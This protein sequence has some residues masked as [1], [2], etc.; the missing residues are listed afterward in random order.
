M[1]NISRFDTGSSSSWGKHNRNFLQ[2]LIYSS[3]C[4]I[5]YHS[6]RFIKLNLVSLL[7][8]SQWD[9]HI[10]IPATPRIVIP[11]TIFQSSLYLYF[12][13]FMPAF[14]GKRPRKG[15]CQRISVLI[16]PEPFCSPRRAPGP[17]CS[18]WGWCRFH[19]FVESLWT[20]L[21]LVQTPPW[22]NEHRV[23]AGWES[24]LTRVLDLVSSGFRSDEQILAIYLWVA[25]DLSL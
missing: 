3:T 10:H 7:N 15:N 12:P 17:Q 21:P 5:I 8:P 14:P 4:Y 25:S 6:G 1:D 18:N 13:N 22:I 2:W 24:T 11:N 19:P 20:D 9:K 16:S 23:W